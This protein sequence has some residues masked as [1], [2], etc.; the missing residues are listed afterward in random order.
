M[1]KIVLIL[2]AFAATLFAI[3]CNKE[4][5]TPDESAQLQENELVTIKVAIPDE[6]SK[7]GLAYN[8]TTPAL[9]LTWS[10]GDVIRVADHSNPSTNYQDFTLV[11]GEGTKNA[12]FS[13]TAISAASYDITLT[14]NMPSGAAV[15][16]QT[17]ST[18]ANTEHLG[19]N[20]TL[21]GVSTYEDVAFSNA[22][23]TSKGGTFAQ[24]GALHLQAT[25]PAGV[26]A[27]VNGVTMVAD[28]NIFGATGTMNVAISTP[29]DTGSDGVLDVYA[30]IPASGVSIPSGT[31]LLFKFNTTDGSHSVYTRHYLTSSALNLAGGQLNKISLT[32]TNIDKYAGK[33]DDG[34]SAHPYLIADKYQMLAMSGL[35][36]SGETKY[37]KLMADIDLDGITWTSLNPDD[38]SA[39][40]FD[41]NNFTVSHLN[42]PLFTYLDGKVSNLTISDATVNGG[43]SNYYG[44][45]AR[46]VSEDK[47]CDLSNV[48]VKKSTLS[49]KGSSGGLIGRIVSTNSSSLTN[50]SVDVDVTGT[51]YYIGGIA[52]QVYNCTFTNCSSTGDVTTSS[53]Y[54]GGLIGLANNTIRLE[55]CYSTGNIVTT[56]NSLANHG[57]IVGYTV[58]TGNLTIINC[59][60]T[61]AIGTDTY[62]TRR[63]CGGILGTTVSGSTI[64]V[65]NCYSSCTITS[66]NPTLEG[67]LV[68]N[69]GSTA[70]TCSGFVGWSSLSNLAGAGTAVST[71]GN[72]LGTEGTISSHATT[73]GWDGSIWDLTGSVPTL[74]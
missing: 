3:S 29:A 58:A 22:W 42:K 59:Y 18:D 37:F 7:V 53:H 65:I 8:S 11:S 39:I 69:N 47:K 9:E 61:G 46:T 15:L 19:Y 57:G 73:L 62:K 5:N 48:S 12:T 27:V 68:G 32:C 72:Y 20:A 64:D 25:L 36:A 49:A 66:A 54:A 1:K 43:T 14:S 2:A 34:T 38:D 40:D 31:N 55:K 33:D 23:A 41:G 16:A 74:K 67:A 30:T 60:S 63:W 71:T 17:Q 28:K 6:L 26:A 56:A 45:L 35:M 21:S 70:L 4:Q 44:V 50:C 10:A 51:Y 52:G 13:G 24:S